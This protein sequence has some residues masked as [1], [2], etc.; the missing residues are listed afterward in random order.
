MAVVKDV[1]A[2]RWSEIRECGYNSSGAAQ[3]ETRGSREGFREALTSSDSATTT[4]SIA[5]QQPRQCR[6]LVDA[7]TNASLV[8]HESQLPIQK[9][10]AAAQQLNSLSGRNS[11]SFKA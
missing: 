8:F 10:P 3:Q 1:S 6:Q 2:K 5:D 7:Q 9:R 4:D 11:K